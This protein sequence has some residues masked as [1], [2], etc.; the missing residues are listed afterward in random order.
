MWKR[1]G[2]IRGMTKPSS[3]V[4]R[5]YIA[6]LRAA[7]LRRVARGGDT[8]AET[9]TETI[10]SRDVGLQLEGTE[11]VLAASLAANRRLVAELEASR[12]EGEGYRMTL[13]ALRSLLDAASL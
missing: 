11:R 5:Q 8:G 7:L 9:R 4:A 13:A 1:C 2:T 6:G 12:R 10:D 3:L